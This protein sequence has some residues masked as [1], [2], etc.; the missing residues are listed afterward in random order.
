MKINSSHVVERWNLKSNNKASINNRKKRRN[1]NVE[2]E[3]EKIKNGI[4]AASS[5]A[6]REQEHIEKQ[7]MCLLFFL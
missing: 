4:K 3:E 5:V 2:E 1:E 7:E 6:K